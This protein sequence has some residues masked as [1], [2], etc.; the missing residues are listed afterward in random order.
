MGIL[1]LDESG[2][3][4]DQ[5]QY[6]S[7]IGS[8]LY[9]TTSRSDIMFSD[10]CV[11]GSKLHLKSATW[12]PSKESWDIWSILSML[13]C[14]ILEMHNLSL[15]YSDSDYAECKV[16]SKRISDT[17]IARDVTCAVILKH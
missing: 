6:R 10:V 15:L 16:G 2:S 4:V 17:S 3:S 8:L 5:K 9:L 1:D 7:M 12:V 13:V 14:G 11:Q